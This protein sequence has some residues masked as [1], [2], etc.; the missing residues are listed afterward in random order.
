MSQ[1]YYTVSGWSSASF[2]CHKVNV[3]VYHL[4]CVV[5]TVCVWC[6]IDCVCHSMY[7]RVC[8]VC[9]CV[10]TNVCGTRYLHPE[11]SHGLWGWSS[12][13]CYISTACL[14]H[15][16][17]LTS[18]LCSLTWKRL[19]QFESN[20]AFLFEIE[21]HGVYKQSSRKNGQ[22]MYSYCSI[23]VQVCPAGVCQQ[24][25]A[26]WWRRWREGVYSDSV[27]THSTPTWSVYCR[28]TRYFSTARWEYIIISR[29]LNQLLVYL[30]RNTVYKVTWRAHEKTL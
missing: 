4:W 20:G 8:A 22:L 18:I 21:N 15:S 9:V 12:Q 17:S 29:V 27:T 7:S 19:L 3:H 24:Q 25:A 30:R 11:Y 1:G 10:C 28:G 26:S 14:M 16:W 6:E 13:Q 5:L 23:V 2:C